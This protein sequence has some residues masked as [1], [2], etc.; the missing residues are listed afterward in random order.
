MFMPVANLGPLEKLKKFT[1]RSTGAGT[2][3]VPVILFC[4]SQAVEKDT[5]L[6]NVSSD[7]VHLLFG[8]CN[9]HFCNTFE[10][11]RHG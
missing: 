5:W 1:F 4:W 11:C 6:M 8:K 10:H 9:G 2:A 7:S 3:T